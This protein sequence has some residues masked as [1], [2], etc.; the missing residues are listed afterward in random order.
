MRY[1]LTKLEPQWIVRPTRYGVG[2]TF[3]CPSIHQHCRVRVHFRRPDDGGPPLEAPTYEHQGGK[4]E[5]LTVLQHFMH[6]GCIL[7]I[8]SGVVFV[9]RLYDD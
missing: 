3:N 8:Y 9:L 6:G 7:V 2:V 1:V 4:L 5:H